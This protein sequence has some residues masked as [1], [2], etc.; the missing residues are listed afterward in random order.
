L[1]GNGTG[2]ECAI[3]LCETYDL[4]NT[5]HG[6]ADV[7]VKLR[8]SFIELVFREGERLAAAVVSGPAASPKGERAPKTS[9]GQQAFNE[10]YEPRVKRMVDEL[11]I[12]LRGSRTGMHYHNGLIQVA[13]DTMTQS[14]IASPFWDVVCDVRDPKWTN[15]DR[16]M[17][18]AIDRRDTGG[19]DPAVYALR[20]L[21]STVKVISAQ[22]GWT[23][24][25]ETGASSFIDHLQS[26]KNG[27]F[28]DG[29]EADALRQMFRHIRNPVVHGEGGAPPLQ[30]NRHQ[31]NL[32]IESCMSWIKSLALRT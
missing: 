8:M 27:N 28:I 9:R 19:R 31:T 14:Q 15:V 4:F 18:E 5:T 20:A 17:K 10:G 11:N 24:G 25:K 2:R 30:L 32:I 13:H 26:D 1:I 7:F 16:D 22:K 3:F 23:T 21:E 12:R 29:W 6:T